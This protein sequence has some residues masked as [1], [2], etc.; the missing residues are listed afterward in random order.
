MA[1]TFAQNYK[2]TRLASFTVSSIQVSILASTTIRLCAAVTELLRSA[3]QPMIH[4]YEGID[5][6][7]R[8]WSNVRNACGCQTQ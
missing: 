5:G 1:A 8:F 7:L 3:A 6:E 2:H 4:R